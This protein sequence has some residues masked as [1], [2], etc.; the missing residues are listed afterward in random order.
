MNNASPSNQ[1]IQSSSSLT[2]KHNIENNILSES[3]SSLSIKEPKE[4]ERNPKIEININEKNE[5]VRSR[6]ESK[7]SN[8]NIKEDYFEIKNGCCKNCMR[9]FN[10]NGKACLCQVPKYERKYMLPE[11]GCNYCGCHGCNPIDVRINKKKKL[12]K[13]YLEDKTLAYKNQRILDSDDEDL[14]IN[15]K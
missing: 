14:K 15:E 12:K 7:E 4:E 6:S 2:Q 11:S 13:Q 1:N 9:A 3:S 8:N 5:L 10:K